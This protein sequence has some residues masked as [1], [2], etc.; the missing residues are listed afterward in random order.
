MGGMIRR[1]FLGSLL[2]GAGML[3]ARRGSAR[4]GKSTYR[5]GMIG[6]EG[7]TNYTVKPLPK[8]PNVRLAAIAVSEE[9]QARIQ[10]K[11]DQLP[12][13]IKIYRDHREMLEKES[14]DIASVYTPHGLTANRII[15]CAEA[16]AH[17]FTEKPLSTTLEDLARV[18]DAVTRADA[19]MTMMLNMRGYG[20]Y[21][22]VHE[23]VHGGVI[24][25]VTQC[26]VQKSYKLGG[27]PEWV[28]SR[29]TYA[30]TIPYIGCHAIDLIRWCSGLQF[31]KG[32]AFHNNIGR[33]EIGGMENS[34][35]VILLAK[36]G[37][38]VSVRLDYCR[39]DTAPTWGN[40]RLRIAG[41]EGIVEV[42]HEKI[43]LMTSG[44]PPFEV[45]PANDVTQLENLIAAIEG[46][47]P[48]LVPTEDCYRI[49]E[50][51]LKLRNAA[52]A[53]T[54]VEL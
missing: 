29:D 43:T 14:L 24:G 12:K 49:C 47:E 54:M 4:D 10:K 37:A 16:G 36:N 28:R 11:F 31:V 38:T 25:E 5:L 23:I 30:G 42:L 1:D 46:R 18:K 15:D 7:H 45:P 53:Q 34:A 52:D 9:E 20:I 39:P 8:L 22:K 19:V 2:A 44:K 33:P 40:D 21:R 13:D 27:R 35:S 51:I 50:I 41:T 48:L 6:L 26:T 32:A 3:V 17:I